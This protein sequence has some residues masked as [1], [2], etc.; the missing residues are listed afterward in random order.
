M[1]V[2]SKF[3]TELKCIHD[4]EVGIIQYMMVLNSNYMNPV[5]EMKQKLTFAPAPST[6]FLECS[7][8]P[9]H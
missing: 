8:L 2:H 9:D 6:L 7:S 1:Q 3:V 5:L 4:P